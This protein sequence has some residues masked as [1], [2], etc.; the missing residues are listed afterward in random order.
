MFKNPKVLKSQYMS[1]FG[2]NILPDTLQTLTEHRFQAFS[3]GA[4][5]YVINY[6]LKGYQSPKVLISLSL[7]MFGQVRAE[8][9]RKVTHIASKPTQPFYGQ[10]VACFATFLG[11]LLL[12][13]PPFI[14]VSYCLH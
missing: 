1:M 11:R 8:I 12:S 10:F 4:H 3:K 5:L 14:A 6:P 13:P 7:G 9:D 2:L